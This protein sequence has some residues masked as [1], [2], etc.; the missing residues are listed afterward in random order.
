MA[1]NYNN[2][3]NKVKAKMN[4]LSRGSTLY[5]HFYTPFVNKKLLPDPVPSIYGQA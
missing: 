3:V 1:P 2:I 4:Y 5:Y